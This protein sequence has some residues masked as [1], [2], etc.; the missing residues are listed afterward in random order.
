MTQPIFGLLVRPR[1]YR[2]NYCGHVHDVSTNHTDACFAHCPNCYWRGGTV[3]DGKVFHP[4]RMDGER[5]HTYAGDAPKADE[6]NPH[7]RGA[8]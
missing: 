3:P 7:A 6:Y 4:E 2:C 1:S 8:Q 5:P